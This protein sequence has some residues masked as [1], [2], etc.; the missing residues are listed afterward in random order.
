M[1]NTELG[2]DAKRKRNLLFQYV[3][4]A[5]YTKRENGHLHPV[6][7]A[8]LYTVLKEAATKHNVTGRTV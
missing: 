3:G 2:I 8:F 4:V 1:N 6:Q 7:G 5:L